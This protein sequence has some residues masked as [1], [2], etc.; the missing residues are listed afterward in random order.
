MTQ[1]GTFADGDQFGGYRLG[2]LIGRGGM[3]EVYEAF[4]TQKERVV[5][6]KVLPAE[7][8]GD[9]EFRRRFQHEAQIAAGLQEPH[10]IPIHDYG[11]ID[12]QLF[13]DMRLVQGTD[14]RA[15]LRDQGRLEAAPALD[16][17]AQVGDALD[18]AHQDGLVHRDVKP[19]NVMVLPS[20]FAYLADFGIAVRDGQ[21]RLTNHGETVG[22]MAY[23]APE[24]FDGGAV[25]GAADIYSLGCLLYE[26]LTGRVPFSRE[27]H[28]ATLHAH[29]YEEPTPVSALRPDL[30]PDVDAVLA[31]AM[32]KD[33]RQR[34]A[35]AREMTDALVGAIGESRTA[36]AGT[37]LATV[38]GVAALASP[39]TRFPGRPSP[40]GARGPDGV[41][42]PPAPP[43]AGGSARL[44]GPDRGG[45]RRT[46]LVLGAAAAAIALGAGGVAAYAAL[47]DDDDL[48][49]A[50]SGDQSGVATAEPSVAPTGSTGTNNGTE[51]PTTS[52]QPSPPPEETTPAPTQPEST[53]APS[54]SEGTGTPTGSSSPPPAPAPAPSPASDVGPTLATTDHYDWQGWTIRPEARCN[55]NDRALAVISSKSVRASICE[56][57]PGGRTYYRGWSSAGGLEIDDPVPSEN[58][59]LAT[60]GQVSY[61]LGRDWVIIMESTSE[62]LL[63]EPTWTYRTP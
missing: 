36:R 42:G 49:A 16:V 59:W 7:L 19:S 31:V 50:R 46:R 27:S 21:D 11:E 3:G 35:S 2:R 38:P 40:T 56:V 30:P 29:L 22:S 54:P 4:D 37:A 43:G 33:P 14:L 5:A 39:T 58:G 45:S 52:E 32:A 57:G 17:I 10:V 34:Y 60:R 28:A 51:A 12:G 47:G 18:A 41:H 53:T 63:D 13:I 8:S 1:A 15:V 62:V 44:A 25:T 48:P 61:M 20:G 26:C 23:M 9:P 55:A 6:L 24:R